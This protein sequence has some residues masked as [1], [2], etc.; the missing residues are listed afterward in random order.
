M[1]IKINEYKHA[2]EKT[3]NTKSCFFGKANKIEKPLERLTTKKE[4]KKKTSKTSI[5]EQKKGVAA[6]SK[7]ILR[8]HYKQINYYLIILNQLYHPHKNLHTVDNLQQLY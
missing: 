8:E 7:K 3:N 4:R 1:M 6:E 2:T 5:R